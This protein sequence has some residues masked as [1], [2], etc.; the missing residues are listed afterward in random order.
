MTSIKEAQFPSNPSPGELRKRYGELRQAA[1]FL[2]RSRGQYKGQVTRLTTRITEME[3]E[4]REFATAAEMTLCQ[5]AE[6]D[7]LML[8]YHDV[9]E[10]FELAGD[11]LEDAW[12]NYQGRVWRG[13]AI[14]ELL[15]AVTTFIKSWL[16][17]KK[18]KQELEASDESA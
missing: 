9:F 1:Q 10:G 11:E 12:N 8:K 16:A 4:L 5:K 7:K 3:G 13:N 6:L 18:A 17:A 15:D 14:T 2:S